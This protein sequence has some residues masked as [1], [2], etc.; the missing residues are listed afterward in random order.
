MLTLKNP[1]AVLAAIKARPTDVA[2]IT[3]RTDRPV[4][5][6]REVVEAAAAAG[7]PVRGG[8]EPPA[9]GRR[10]KGRDKESRAGIA[11]ASVRER[12]ETPLDALFGD[13]DPDRP[14]LWVAL[15]QV[16]DPHNVGAV[17]RSA[18]FFGVRGLILTKDRSAPLSAV[19]YDTACGGIEAVPFHQP[20]N[21]ARSLEAAKK[22]G[23]WVLG[24]SEHAGADV[25]DLPRDRPRL[26][27]LGNEQS[28]LRRLT[29][30]KCDEFCRLTPAG[31][32]VTSLNVSAAAAAS[33]AALA[34]AVPGAV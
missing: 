30:D 21:L 13:V 16:Q 23:L 26:I 33:I 20:T 5:A 6:W 34:R 14:D 28:G 17:F 2:E 11:Q 4:D 7:V 31:T 8:A 3:L 25:F 18:A 15:D 12:S 24:T 27:V 10:G 19:A 29:A 9:F 1:H 32:A 22:A